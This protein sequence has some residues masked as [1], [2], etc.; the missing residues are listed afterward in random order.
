[1]HTF[2][3]PVSRGMLHAALLQG[4]YV[5]KNAM[6]SNVSD[7]LYRGQKKASF[8]ARTV[9]VLHVSEK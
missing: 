3:R 2:R 9:G 8:Q 6:V 4:Y 5:P 7:K 1:M